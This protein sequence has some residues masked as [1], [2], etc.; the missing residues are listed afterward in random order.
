MSQT[1]SPGSGKP[2]G[3]ARVCHVW[4]LSRATLY[5]H[6]RPPASEPPRRRGPIGPMADTDLVAA[7][8]SVL[9]DSPFQFITDYSE[10]RN[11]PSTVKSNRGYGKRYIIPHLGQMK[12]PDVT[13]AD[14]ANLMKKMSKCLTRNLTLAIRLLRALA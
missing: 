13:R 5:R 3:T 6:R 7:I 4:R 9:A 14:I 10:S 2:Y 1:T 12:V 8:R 11:K